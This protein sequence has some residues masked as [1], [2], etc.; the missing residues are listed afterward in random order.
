MKRILGQPLAVSRKEV[1]KD[2]LKAS[3][4]TPGLAVILVGNDAP[5]RLYVSI[6]EREAKA[7]GIAFESVRLPEAASESELLFALRELNEREDIHGIVLQLPLPRGLD[8]DIFVGALLP[9][10]D[11]DGFHKATLEAYFSGDESAL[12]VFPRA[13]RELLLSQAAPQEL[14]GKRGLV[15]GRSMLFCDVTREML[16]RLG[17]SVETAI[18]GKED[19]LP[20]DLLVGADVVVTALG[21]ARLITKHHLKPGVI[22]IDGGITAEEGK[23]WGDFDD[24]GTEDF[25]G[26]YTPVPGGVGPMTVA[27][28]LVRVGEAALR[29]AGFSSEGEAREE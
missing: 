8:P 26:A 5:S 7:S 14:Q 16:E 6:K 12:P 9:E 21:A 15:L 2:R 28:L 29:E 13:V 17:L 4:V 19:A 24:T 10:K 25:P 18:V 23:V 11:T 1:L 27:M 22:L 20:Q 3:G